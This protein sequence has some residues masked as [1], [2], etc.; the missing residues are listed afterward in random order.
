MDSAIGKCSGQR[1]N[2]DVMQRCLHDLDYR[3]PPKSRPEKKPGYTPNRDSDRQPSIFDD[4]L[5]RQTCL[6]LR[7]Y[8][9]QARTKRSNLLL[10]LRQLG[11]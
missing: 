9:L 5:R 8:P 6:Q 3:K 2:D 7:A 11:F 1:G 4:A 10:L